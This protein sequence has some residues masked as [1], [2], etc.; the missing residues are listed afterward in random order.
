MG[1]ATSGGRED[2]AGPHRSLAWND[3]VMPQGVQDRRSGMRGSQRLMFVVKEPFQH[4]H[5]LVDVAETLVQV[6]DL[7]VAGAHP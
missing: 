6:D 7:G 2:T 3:P 4:S 1:L 5:L